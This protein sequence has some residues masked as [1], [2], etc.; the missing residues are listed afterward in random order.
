MRLICIGVCLS[1]GALCASSTGANDSGPKAGEKVTVSSWVYASSLCAKRSVVPS[2]LAASMSGKASPI[3]EPSSS[4]LAQCKPD[5]PIY[6]GEAHDDGTSS[7]YPIDN[8]ETLR[9]WCGKEV[10]ATG[11]VTSIAADGVHLRIETE[12]AFKAAPKRTFPQ[13]D[14]MTNSFVEKGLTYFADLQKYQVGQPS[15]ASDTQKATEDAMENT[16]DENGYLMLRSYEASIRALLAKKLLASIN[17]QDMSE[18]D[19]KPLEEQFT[20]CRN[21]I[22]A[23]LSSAKP[24]PDSECIKRARPVLAKFCPTCP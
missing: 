4:C 21:E 2:A 12:E 15:S 7:F 13:A 11:V 14:R 23:A 20:Q 3:S 22:S 24:N 8:P 19:E 5:S 10:T 6:L 9:A 18:A 1:L 17:G 16:A